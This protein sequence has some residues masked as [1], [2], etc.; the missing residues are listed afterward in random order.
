MPNVWE[1]FCILPTES[2]CSV[3]SSA[4]LR[5]LWFTG[6]FLGTIYL[7]MLSSMLVGSAAGT[8][9]SDVPP[10]AAAADTFSGGSFATADDNG[11]TY[12][13]VIGVYDSA[14]ATNVVVVATF[15]V[16]KNNLVCSNLECHHIV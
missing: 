10:L 9:C 15:T 6:A 16:H 1:F 13:A 8:L 11:A 2:R 7:S 14:T 3:V 4:I 12:V 5:C